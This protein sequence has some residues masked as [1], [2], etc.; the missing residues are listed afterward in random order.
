MAQMMGLRFSVC[1]SIQ[2]NPSLSAADWLIA[3]AV[4]KRI[5]DSIKECQL[6]KVD[7]QMLEPAPKLEVKVFHAQGPDFDSK[8][9]R[10][11]LPFG[12]KADIYSSIIHCSIR[13][14]NLE[15]NR[16]TNVFPHPAV[17]TRDEV[18]GDDR[19]LTT[20]TTVEAASKA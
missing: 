13:L 6:L 14:W 5:M 12:P 10:E 2:S 18:T 4:A 11:S 3:S 9:I 20:D 15:G 17:V 19:P 16:M 7:F 8:V 1:F